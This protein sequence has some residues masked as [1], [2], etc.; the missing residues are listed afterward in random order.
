VADGL[1]QVNG[2][3]FHYIYRNKQLLGKYIDPIFGVI[4]ALQNIPNS[5]VNGAELELSA[6]PVSGLQFSGSITYLDAKI[7][8]FFGIDG[9]G[10]QPADLSG[11]RF[12][13]TPKVTAA[14][15]LEY[16]RPVNEH[17]N[18]FLGSGVTYN[19]S[20]NAGIGEPA[21]LAID[22]YALLDL[23]AGV[24]AADGRWSITAFGRN[25]T[26]TYYWTTVQKPQDT[27][28]RFAGM[29]ATYGVAIRFTMP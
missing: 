14:A 26:D 25:V 11:T 23:R 29:P 3:V 12:P 18:W 22:A 20:T 6:R 1:A 13:Y 7:T 21:P 8:R 16:A 28:V 5:R 15:D 2:S 19:S 9:L 27:L 17:I 4:Q 10:N 24:R